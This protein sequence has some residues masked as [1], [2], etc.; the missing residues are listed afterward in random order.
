MIFCAHSLATTNEQIIATDFYSVIQFIKAPCW[1]GVPFFFCLSGFLITYLLM[2][3]KEKNGRINLRSFYVRRI[4]RIWPLYILLMVFGFGIFPPL[5][6]FFL[7]GATGETITQWKYWAFLSNFDQIEFGLPYAPGLVVAWSLAVEEQFYLIW[8]ILM[9]LVPSRYYLHL[10]L[11]MLVLSVAYRVGFNGHEK[12]T[13]SCILDLSF[14]GLLAVLYIQGNKLFRSMTKLPK[15]VIGVV[16][17][18]GI[19]MLYL[20]YHSGVSLRVLVSVFMCFVIFEQCF[21]ENSLFKMG[22]ARLMSRWGK[23]TYGLY[24][25]HAISLFIVQNLLEHFSLSFIHPIT[26]DYL[27]RPALALALS[28]GLAYISYN[29]FERYFLS[30]KKRFAS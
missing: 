16:Y 12:H 5:Q 30:L 3:E 14:G 7:G 2:V 6:E 20:H 27:I 1:L 19:A 29:W 10:M 13:L 11:G 8:P 21:A 26:N 9:I 17:V 25:V 24:I 22:K 4:L 28:L 23:W 18:L 15:W